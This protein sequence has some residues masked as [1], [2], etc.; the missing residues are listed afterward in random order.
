MTCQLVIGWEFSFSTV[1]FAFNQ[2]GNVKSVHFIPNYI[3]PRNFPQCALVEM[4]DLMQVEAVV[5]M[6]SNHYFMVFGMPRSV[7]ARL[8]EVNMFNDRPK[9]PRKTIQCQWLDENDPDFKV[10]QKIKDLTRL[11]AAQSAFLLK[12]FF[13]F[14]ILF[15][16]F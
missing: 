12:V 13:F 2:F 1:R 6:T 9:M 11:N 3:E 15:S 14:L 4:K 10:A 8:A 7:R 5:S 16:A